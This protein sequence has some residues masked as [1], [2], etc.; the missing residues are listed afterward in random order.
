MEGFYFLLWML[1]KYDALPYTSRRS[2][3]CEAEAGTK[4]RKEGRFKEG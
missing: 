3:E 1:Y 2:C 4:E